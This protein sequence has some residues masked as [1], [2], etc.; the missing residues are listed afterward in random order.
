MRRILLLLS[1]CPAFA[2][3]ATLSTPTGTLSAAQVVSCPTT[4][5]VSTNILCL[6]AASTADSLLVDVSVITLAGGATTPTIDYR[7]LDAVTR[8]IALPISYN[9]AANIPQQSTI[10]TMVLNEPAGCYELLYGCSTSG[11]M[12][13]TSSYQI[14]GAP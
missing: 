5:V 10:H 3:A 11:T 8:A 14:N 12:T 1:L 4:N 13:I 7:H 2:S 6:H 9:G